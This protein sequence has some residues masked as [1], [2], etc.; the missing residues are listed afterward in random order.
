MGAAVAY[1]AGLIAHFALERRYAIPRDVWRSVGLDAYG[2][3]AE[4]RV[5][6]TPSPWRTLGW[7]ISPGD[8]RRDDVFLDYGS[9]MGVMVTA[10][11]ARYSF[12]RVIGIDIVPELNEIAHRIIDRNR[13]RLRCQQ[14]E[15]VTADVRDYVVPDDVTVAYMFNPFQGL[16]FDTAIDRLLA[17]I[18][19]NPRVVRLIYLNP[20]CAPSLLATGRARLVRYGRSAAGAPKP[21]L[22]LYEVLPANP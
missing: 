17:S 20:K 15:I 2:L 5:E 13:R 10:A 22:R 21:D 18:D 11:A 7:I 16:L 12:R 6:Y 8:I 4:D 9:G 1:R 14:V 3:A 19:R